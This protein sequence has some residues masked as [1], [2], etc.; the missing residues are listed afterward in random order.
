MVN[1]LG[2]HLDSV[3]EA[4]TKN[5]WDEANTGLI[6]V[7]KVHLYGKSGS[8]PKRKM[9]HIN[10]LCRDVQDGLNWIEQTNIWRNGHA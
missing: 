2:E 4:M 3:V 5:T 1:V 7:P 10:L 9:G 6:V 8:A